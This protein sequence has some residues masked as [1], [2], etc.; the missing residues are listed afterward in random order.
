MSKFGVIFSGIGSQWPRMGA[1]LLDE[2]VFRQTLEACAE[3]FAAYAGWSILTELRREPSRLDRADIGA[4]CVCALEIALFEL[5][6]SWGLPVDGVV[7]HSVGELPAAYAAGV[8][9]LDTVLRLQWQHCRIMQA[10][11][12]GGAMAH[13]GQPA[14][15]VDELLASRPGNGL[16]IAAYNSPAATVVAGSAARVNALV[17]DLTRR[18]IFCRT[19]RVNL[20][21]HAPAIESHRDAFYQDLPSMQPRPPALPVYSTLRG[22]QAGPDDFD[23]AYWFEQ[24]RH[25]VRFTQAV[26]A[27][28]A[29]G[30]DR[31][32][33]IGP[34]PTL[35]GAMHEV[36]ADA[37]PGD[38]RYLA[39]L[40]RDQDDRRAL[41]VN[42]ALLADD[43]VSLRLPGQGTGT[44][45]DDARLAGPP[46]DFDAW[47][48]ERRQEWLSRVVDDALATVAPELSAV[49][50]D[51]SFSEL[52]LTSLHLLRIQRLLS[53]RLGVSLPPTLCFSHPT[54]SAVAGALQPLVRVQPDTPA[55]AASGTKQQFQVFDFIETRNAPAFHQLSRF[56]LRVRKQDQRRVEIDGKPFIDFAS[57]NYLGLDYHPDVMAAIP[58]M[59]A[60]W[61]VHPS[62]TR[63]VAS[64]EPYL[65]L[66]ERLAEFLNVPGTVVFPSIAG[67]NIGAL[68][69]LAGPSGVILCD[70]SAHHTIQ[71]ACQLA[72]AKGITSVHYNH[73]DPDDLERLLHQY[74]DRAPV[75]VTVDGVYSMTSEY[76]DLPVYGELMR[77]YNAYLFVDDAH[78][79]GVIGERPSP[80]CPYGHKGNGIVNYF[81]LNCERE[82]IIYVSGLSKAF[83]SYAAFL[84][85]PDADTRQRLQLSSTYVFSG[86]VPV[87]SLASALAGLEVNAAEGDALRAT[88]HR[89]SRRLAEGARALGY[90]VDNTG[91]F[92]IVFVVTGGYEQT[93]RA[94][95]LAWEGGLL[96]S[97]GIFPASPYDRGGLRFSLTALNTDEEIETALQ[98]LAEMRDTI[99]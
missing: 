83:S 13:I 32:I 91:D 56:H 21:F 41:T 7:G 22:R 72:T 18:D 19:L 36:F 50:D 94:I 69:V 97:P 85:C 57:C 2:T 92:P 67:L 9:D 4:P 34:H 29:D 35:A 17:A 46:A 78:G 27:M 47:T 79:L 33:E 51:A 90:E 87:A 8:F 68:P 37:P 88:L 86:P 82:R 43:G 76:V 24:I 64:P 40:E 73:N 48:P 63:L 11:M 44:I 20:P 59:V 60:E 5:L 16:T 54:R 65:E 71:E 10:A 42:L 39:S 3:R 75:I 93:V 74:R 89:V 96:I 62:W 31:F 23:G 14:A 99:F 38:R 30:Y 1:A 25:P 15:R 84:S 26:Q 53:E 12:D 98:V 52:G 80:D 28:L 81:G 55:A 95:N 66:E 45:P 58:E 49:P 61:G 77:R 70:R 6:R